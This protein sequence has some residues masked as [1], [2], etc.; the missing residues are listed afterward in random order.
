MKTSFQVRRPSRVDR[1]ERVFLSSSNTNS[2]LAIWGADNHDVCEII[3]NFSQQSNITKTLCSETL[4]PDFL[5]FIILSV[6][7]FFP[8]LKVSWQRQTL[9]WQCL[10]GPH[11]TACVTLRQHVPSST[12]CTQRPPSSTPET[13][14]RRDTCS[15]WWEP[16]L[17]TKTGE[18]LF[19]AG[20]CG[21]DKPLGWSVQH[22]NQAEQQGSHNF[23]Q[24][25]ADK[26]LLDN[27][28]LFRL[29]AM[30][31]NP[32]SFDLRV[33]VSV[34]DLFPLFN[35]LNDLPQGK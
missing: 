1:S 33:P 2:W 26:P 4:F 25:K 32:W 35:D 23:A 20:L 6:L 16:P 5:F 22:T 28:D 29:T 11:M 19:W 21:Q 17:I 13:R 8:V 15:S 24:S 34:V 14:H 30:A 9:C 10:P 27:S 12:L 3:F 7:R 31:L 18:C